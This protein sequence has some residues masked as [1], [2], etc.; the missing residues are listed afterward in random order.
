MSVNNDFKGE[1]Y[2]EKNRDVNSAKQPISSLK[3]VFRYNIDL[4]KLVYAVTNKEKNGLHKIAS[5]LI[6]K[7]K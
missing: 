3:T 6:P 5:F 1:R 4:L 2:A 7:R